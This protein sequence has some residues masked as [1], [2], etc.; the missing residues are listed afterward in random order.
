ML[1]ALQLPFMQR[2]ALEIALLAP[3]A[4]VLGAQIVLRHL[5]FF[6]HGV[7]AAAFPGL[8][9]AGPVGIP[10]ALAALGAGGIFTA[11]LERL[12]RRRGVALDAA[13]A[14]VLVLALAGGIV[15]ASDVYESGSEVDQLLFGSLLA[16]GDGEI[17]ATAL[18][19]TVGV[20]AA[21]HSRR[22]WLATGFDAVSS[23]SLG[24]RV[25]V[26]DWLLLG[27]IA[28]AVVVSLDAVGALLVSAVLVIP[29]A[30]AR[31]F[32]RSITQLEVGAASLAIV[33]GLVGLLIAYELDVP[34]GAAIATLGGLTFAACL[35]VREAP[36]VAARGGA[37]R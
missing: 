27:S 32:A 37:P 33:E 9:L 19:L 6:A 15:L 12:G 16:I 31:L 18:A 11:G 30:T 23:R 4:G 25:R 10:P 28:I 20:I 17:A 34:P 35:I 5:A 2:A 21:L 24:L 22:A 29:A 8:V 26:A 7:G 36:G 1:E 13:T 14:L 3:L